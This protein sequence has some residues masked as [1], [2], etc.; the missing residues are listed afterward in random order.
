MGDARG[1]I[2]AAG[3]DDDPE[4][5]EAGERKGFKGAVPAAIALFIDDVGELAVGDSGVNVS[6]GKKSIE[7]CRHRDG[8]QKQGQERQHCG[9]S[10][11]HEIF[12]PG[13][14]AGKKGQFNQRNPLDAVYRMAKMS[15]TTNFVRAG[16]GQAESWAY[17]NL[18]D[19]HGAK[20]DRISSI[21]YHA[22]SESNWQTWAQPGVAAVFAVEKEKKLKLSLETRNRGDVV[23]VHCQ[24][25]IV[26]RD[27]AAALSSLVG[28]LLQDGSRVVLDLSGVSSMDSAGIGEL[29]LLGN[30]GAG[31]ER[32]VEVCGGE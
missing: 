1:A 10:F 32:G 23:I 15:R 11:R 2:E 30:L 26:Y 19:I 14:R 31:K 8:E 25:R 20:T 5:R 16:S 6:V 27:E 9:S 4:V 28:E 7:L 13:G 3:I 18:T 22:N 12:L 17:E 29:A 21:H 24:G